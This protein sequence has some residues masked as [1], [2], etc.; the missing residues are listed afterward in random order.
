MVHNLAYIQKRMKSAVEIGRTPASQPNIFELNNAVNRPLF[1][2]SVG[3][4]ELNNIYQPRVD[5]RYKDEDYSR[6]IDTKKYYD[7]PY[8]DSLK[9][10]TGKLYDPKNKTSSNT[11]NTIDNG[12]RKNSNNL[13]SIY[14]RAVENNSEKFQLYD[15]RKNQPSKP[16]PFKREI[17]KE[18]GGTHKLELK[19]SADS[20]SPIKE[21]ATI[22]Y[23]KI[24]TRPKDSIPSFN[25]FRNSIESSDSYIGKQEDDYYQK[26]NLEKQY[27][28]SKSFDRTIQGNTVK[29]RGE[30]SFIIKGKAFDGNNINSWNLSTNDKFTGDKINAIDIIKDYT[31]PD[32]VYTKA[33]AKDFVKFYFADG[34]MQ[35]NNL[36]RIMAF[37]ATI[38]GLTDTFSPSW[39][40]IQIM[41]RPDSVYR[42]SSF[43]RSISFSFK[44]YAMTR[45]EMIP[46]WRKLNYLAS[47]TA[48]DYVGGYVA[49]PFM[50]LT[51]GD[52]YQNC[53]GFIESLSY[54]IPDD[55]VWDIAD[56]GNEDSK[57]L[58]TMIDVSVGYKI[59]GT[60][61]PINMGRMYALSNNDSDTENENGQWLGNSNKYQD[62]GTDEGGFTKGTADSTATSTPAGT[63]SSPL[64]STNTNSG[65]V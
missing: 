42:Y 51:L 60:H 4:S 37:R 46:M 33:R 43:E 7:S 44:A 62:P 30:K 25:D 11:I 16:N 26:F 22:A 57:Q 47:F 39:D 12:S 34:E 54:T 31:N 55:A 17:L 14:N 48:P 10:D 2:S 6:L 52:L 27:G 32:D 59:I 65:L 1:I 8:A 18:G 36:R 41:G 20:T 53:P 45:S 19:R 23:N 24:P 13:K 56:D 63:T 61:R 49:G 50:R 58:P 3:R 15:S 28:F 9:A 40:S 5:T 21:Y 29:A 35:G 64:S 38:T